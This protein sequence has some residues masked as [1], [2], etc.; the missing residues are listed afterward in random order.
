[1]SVI[2]EVLY[3]LQPYFYIL[4]R[5]SVIDHATDADYIAAIAVD[6]SAASNSVGM[7]LIVKH[8]QQ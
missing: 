4:L 7:A 3:I 2:H 5:K 8:R 1:M 6:D